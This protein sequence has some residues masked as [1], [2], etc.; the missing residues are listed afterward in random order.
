[1]GEKKLRAVLINGCI[2]VPVPAYLPGGIRVN[3][4]GSTTDLYAEDRRMRALYT[5]ITHALPGVTA[6]EIVAAVG[7]KRAKHGGAA[8]PEHRHTDS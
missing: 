3:A 7:E 2:E 5:E 1:M 6:K 4:D 8:I